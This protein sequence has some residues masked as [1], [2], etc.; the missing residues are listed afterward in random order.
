[1]SEDHRIYF[2]N[3]QW[4]E[5]DPVHLVD[6]DAERERLY[7]PLKAFVTAP[8]DPRRSLSMAV[9]GDKGVG[10]SIV[11]LAVL[12]RLREEHGGQVV[13]IN[14]DCR[15]RRGWREVLA[16]I[17]EKLRDDLYE[18][19][20]IHVQ[21]PAYAIDGA[22]L[23]RDLGYLDEAKEE[24]LAEYTRSY[25]SQ[26]RLGGAIELRRLFEIEL[27]IDLKVS[28]THRRAVV[29]TRL[30]DDGR[31]SRLL[32]ALLADLARDG[33]RVVVFIDNLDELE[34]NYTTE[35]E[36]DHVRQEVEG[37]L[38]L[39]DAPIAL[40]LNARTYFAGAL[41][42]VNNAPLRLKPLPPAML[43]EV[44]TR[45]MEY[46]PPDHQRLMAAPEVEEE[47]RWLCEV[48]VSPL[49]LLFHVN[50]RA[51]A[52]TLRPDARAEGVR[53]E[54]ESCFAPF[55]LDQIERVIRV[56]NTGPIQ[57]RVALEEALGREYLVKEAMKQQ[58]I[59]PVNFWAPNEFTLDPRLFPLRVLLDA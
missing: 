16:G 8:P 59:L 48:S 35:A 4:T 56:F 43:R 17:A 49:E 36:R 18:L 39:S 47:L 3:L 41:N 5:T 11:T 27:G 15:R 19:Q 2:Q 32:I 57:S 25:S 6:R 34:H 9:V 13:T 44:V 1:M 52:G 55:T 12:K 53:E 29:G 45:R 51:Q 31:V 37:L 42:R 28:E 33:L 7:R 24:R 22:S 54:M 46:E 14:V 10:K 50:H 38:T 23:L 58:L 30:L 21:L 40:I 26:G 20:T